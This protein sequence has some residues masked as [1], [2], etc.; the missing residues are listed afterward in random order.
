MTST[1][2]IACEQ[3]N[4]PG[5][6]ETIQAVADLPD[7]FAPPHHGPRNVPITVELVG[8]GTCYTHFPIVD[9]GKYAVFLD[10]ENVFDGFI[11]GGQNQS[12]GTGTPIATEAI[13][14]GSLA[15]GFCSS[16]EIIFASD[17]PSPIAIKLK[18][19][20]GTTVRYIVSAYSD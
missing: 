15:A 4:I 13:E 16:G 20:A 7:V 3:F 17:D 12:S 2:R 9:T 1:V 11:Y 19:T 6:G 8:N 5:A 10:T 14:S 18:G